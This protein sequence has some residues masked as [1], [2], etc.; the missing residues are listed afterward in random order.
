MRAA[1]G[2]KATSIQQEIIYLLDRPAEPFFVPKGERGVVFEAPNREFLAERLRPMVAELGSRWGGEVKVPVSAVAALPDL[3]LPL[4]LPRRASFSLFIPLHRKIAARLVSIFLGTKTYEEFL[5]LSVYAR[6]RL[7][8]YL[9]VYALSVAILHHPDT[10]GLRLPAL[11]EMFPGRYMHRG[12]I[13]MARA[14]AS[15]LEQT[16][17]MPINVPRDYTASDLD[18]EHRVAYFR[19]DLGINLHHWHWHLVYPNVGDRKIVNKDRR[20]ELFYYMHQQIIARYNFE[21]LC[22]R[23][24]RVTRLLNLREP[25]E[26]GY[27][28]KLD[29]TVASRV[30]QPRHAGALLHNINREQD[31]LRFDLE[32]LERWRDRIIEAIHS[33]AVMDETGKRVP[34]SEGE[35]IDRLGNIVES[36]VLSVNRSLYGDLHNLGHVAIAY[37]HDPDARHLETFSV[38]GDPA[39]AMRDPVFYRWHATIDDLFQMHK[40]ALPAY[41]V[42]Q[43]DYPGI[44]ITKVD[45]VTEGRQNPNEFETFW[46]QRD[47]DLSRGLDFSPRGPVFARFSHL[48]HAPFTYKITA[49]NS[50]NKPVLGTVR[51]FLA[52]K[53]DER[54]LEMLFRDQKLLF[55]EMDKFQITLK[56]KPTANVIERASSSSSISIP[57]ERTFQDLESPPPGMT[58]SSFNYCGCGWPQ[59]MLVPK[60]TSEGFPCQLFVMISNF[61]DD[62]VN[63]TP[64]PITKCPDAASFCGLRDKKYPDKRSMGY[65]FDR[66][67]RNGVD[68]IYHFLTPNMLLMDVNIFFSGKTESPTP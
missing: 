27:F 33:G 20:G 57:F 39:T 9:F 15:I 35:G 40:N 3:S 65:P 56:S 54:G 36:S 62:K 45:L 67:P 52:P 42:A 2:G 17:R 29:S 41:T 66:N 16:N 38:M 28:P 10:R 8:P 48:Q 63:Q 46:Q 34:L 5:S 60:G 21:R 22:N 13:S 47:L 7:N 18:T 59:N 49:E 23:L 11:A 26:E 55:I 19:E 30:W 6:D 31:Q 4:Q 53:Y 12:V 61:N 43:L 24:G 58:E 68:T 32:D 50:I 37:A 14:Q 64:G 51:I 25:I 1:T 44:K